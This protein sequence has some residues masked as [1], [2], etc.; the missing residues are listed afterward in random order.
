MPLREWF[1]NLQLERRGDTLRVHSVYNVYPFGV[2]WITILLASLVLGLRNGAIDP[3]SFGDILGTAILGFAGLVM[4]TIRT[5]D[6]RCVRTV[7]AIQE[8]TGLRRIT[9]A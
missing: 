3:N 4:L 2:F 9:D 6:T 7:E 5:I 1:G 8:A